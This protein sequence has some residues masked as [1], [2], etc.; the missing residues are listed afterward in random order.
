MLILQKKKGFIMKAKGLW[1]VLAAWALASAVTVGLGPR[2]WADETSGGGTKPAATETKD[3]S[4]ED[5]VKELDEAAESDLPKTDAARE[6]ALATKYGVEVAK[7]DAMRTSKMGWGEI[8]IAL[9]LAA[10]LVKDS[11]TTPPLTMDAAL[12]QI[13]TLRGEKI[14]WGRIAKQLGYRLGDIVSAAHRNA[15]SIK[16][17]TT[18]PPKMERPEKPMKPDRTGA[19]DNTG[20]P[21]KTGKPEGAGTPPEKGGSDVHGKPDNPGKAHD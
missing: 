19:P 8:E 7:I 1:T 6:Q 3:V 16:T 11:T 15:E 4:D 12:T 20:K 18:R 13:Q 21:E 10:R 14:G 5:A 17:E 2:A 9:A